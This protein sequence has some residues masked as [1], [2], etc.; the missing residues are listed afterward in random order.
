MDSIKVASYTYDS[1]GRLAAVS[2]PRSNL[3]TGYGYNA[4]NHLTSVT[5]PGQVPVQLN[6]VVSEGREKLS[7]VTRQRP[8]GD[9]TGGTATLAHFVYD[10]PLS[11]AGLPD[12][13]PSTIGK[14]GQKS[15][16]AK[17]F[18]VFGPDHPISGSPSAGDWQYADLQYADASGYTVNSAEYGAGAWQYT[19]TDYDDKGNVVRELDQRALRLMLDEQMGSATADQ[20]STQTVY[21]ADIKNAAGE[22]VTQAGTLVTDTY[23]P[24]KSAVLKDGTPRWVR[25][26]THTNYDQS[27]PNNGINPATGLPYRLETS[28][29]GTAFDP[30]TG[31][32]LEAIAASITEYSAVATGDTDGWVLGLETRSIT[33]VDLDGQ[34]SSGD[35][36]HITKHDSEG[37]DRRL[38]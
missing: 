14:W 6:Y 2:D 26:H 18:A 29:Q 30:G 24:A 32:D 28:E 36:V 23:G 12:M 1:A 15:V 9:P 20:L 31:Q 21:N 10:V 35:H 19:A 11:G 37:V 8:A 3:A 22:T 25:S 5:P 38:R 16:P 13:T 7:T 27:A 4:A 33:D 17:G 34:V